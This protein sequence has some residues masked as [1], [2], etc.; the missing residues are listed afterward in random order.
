MFNHTIYNLPDLQS[1]TTES[2][3]FYTTPEGNIFPSVT[4][5][6]NQVSDKTW[7]DDWISRVGIEKVK[8]V[9]TQATNRGSAVHSIIEQYLLNN[10]L[11]KQNHMPSTIHTFN[12]IKHILDE[13]INEIY[14]LEVPLYSTYLKAAGRTD[15]IGVWDG[16]KSVIDFKTSKKIK[17]KEQIKD[18]FLQESCYSYM[19]YERTGIT[20]P[21]IVTV[22]TVDNEQPLIFIERAKTYLPEFIELRKKVPF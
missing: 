17:T 10:P 5:I 2:G 1:K 6:L 16:V 15:C 13:H 14:G 3:R 18:Y 9:S 8:Q 22:M 19:F 21:Q 7:Y 20:L 4:T 11:Y 12:S